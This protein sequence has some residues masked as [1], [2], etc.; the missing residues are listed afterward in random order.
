MKRNDSVQAQYD[1]IKLL[2]GMQNISIRK[3]E[4]ELCFSN[5]YIS[6]HRRTGIPSDRL[7]LIAGYLG[8]PLTDLID[9]N[10]VNNINISSYLSISKVLQDEQLSKRLINYAE[11]LL[12]IKKMED[13]LSH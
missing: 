10:N 7:A 3:L 8:V 13:E 6:H 1:K 2:C 4:R 12:E 9:N 5:G 11:K